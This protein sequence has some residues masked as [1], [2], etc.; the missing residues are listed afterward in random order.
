[1][2]VGCK[3]LYPSLESWHSATPYILQHVVCTSW[4]LSSADKWL[5]LAQG[6]LALFWTFWRRT[7]LAAHPALLVEEARAPVWLANV[8]PTFQ[9][10]EGW[11]R[12]LH[13]LSPGSAQTEPVWVA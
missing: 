3:S 7:G 8:V 6:W 10:P 11:Q 13:K 4:L 12:A 9:P 5:L 2:L 1:M